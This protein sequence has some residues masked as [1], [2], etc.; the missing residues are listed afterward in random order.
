MLNFW[1]FNIGLKPHELDDKCNVWELLIIHANEGHG[2][3]DN[4]QEQTSCLH[5]AKFWHSLCNPPAFS[6]KSHFLLSE[7]KILKWNWMLNIIQC[8]LYFPSEEPSDL[9]NRVRNRT[10][11]FW[12]PA[13]KDFYSVLDW[14]H[15]VKEEIVYCEDKIC[16]QKR[17][18]MTSE[19]KME[20]KVA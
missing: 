13:E 2:S 6:N 18:Q 17:I 3:Y 10:W 12:S 14:H 4:P 11:V 5:C 9:S 8:S 16:R 1:P 20:E 19:E 7:I 15:E